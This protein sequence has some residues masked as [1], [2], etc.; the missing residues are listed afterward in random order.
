MTRSVALFLAWGVTGFVASFALLYGFTPVGPVILLVAWLAYR[1][2]PRISK[3]RSPEAFGALAGFGAFWLFVATTLDAH[4]SLFALAG[5]IA[6]S[7]AIV[8]YL[9]G[10]RRRCAE[11]LAAS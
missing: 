8:G 1:Y 4:G 7:A 2:L 6:V 10:G 5:A 11:G 9:V 3:R